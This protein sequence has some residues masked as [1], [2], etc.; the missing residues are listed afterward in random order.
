MKIG[1]KLFL[2]YDKNGKELI[3]E[4]LIIRE[5]RY[6]EEIMTNEGN[7]PAD[8]PVYYILDNCTRCGRCAQKCPLHALVPRQGHYRIDLRFCDGCG[9]CYE[10]CP[11]GAVAKGS[12]ADQ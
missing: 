2:W 11:I 10:I 4:K 9:I 1:K 8:K 7:V 12:E 5:N 3:Q 6:L